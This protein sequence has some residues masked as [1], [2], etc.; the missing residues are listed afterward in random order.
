MALIPYEKVCLNLI[1]PY[2]TGSV[3]YDF[4]PLIYFKLVICLINV[5]S[6]NT[7]LLKTSDENWSNLVKLVIED[8]SL[9]VIDSSLKVDF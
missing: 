7:S 6:P 9:L 1:R 2:K 3:R 8:V 5:R 4:P